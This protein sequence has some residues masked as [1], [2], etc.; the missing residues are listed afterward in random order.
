MLGLKVV[1]PT[2]PGST[3]IFFL[4]G[5]G[6][7]GVVVPA[8]NPSTQEVET[9]RCEFRVNLVY[10]SQASQGTLCFKTITKVELG[11]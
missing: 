4:W 5:R 6:E 2:L 11:I 9:G 3:L 1:P 8:F 7:L 10:L